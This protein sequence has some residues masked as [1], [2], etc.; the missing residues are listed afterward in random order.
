VKHFRRS[1]SY[2]APHSQQVLQQTSG[3]VPGTCKEILAAVTWTELLGQL[4]QI[5][6]RNS[7]RC[8]RTGK[9]AAA[10]HYYGICICTK[11]PFDATSIF[12][13]RPHDSEI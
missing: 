12:R 5:P 11:L 6:L 8:A 9:C 7:V 1:H 4:G 2:S 10:Q 13:S 3:M